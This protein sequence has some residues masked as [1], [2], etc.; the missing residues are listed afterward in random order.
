[1][2]ALVLTE[3]PKLGSLIAGPDPGAQAPVAVPPRV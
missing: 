1:L 2:L 3:M